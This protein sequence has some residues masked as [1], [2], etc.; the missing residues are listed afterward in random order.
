VRRFQRMSDAILAAYEEDLQRPGSLPTSRACASSKRQAFWKTPRPKTGKQPG[1]SHA[2]EEARNSG[3]TLFL[4]PGPE[5]QS[6]A[7]I[8]TPGFHLSSPGAQVGY[9]KVP[10]QCPPYAIFVRGESAEVVVAIRGMHLFKESDYVTFLRTWRAS[11]VSTPPPC[12]P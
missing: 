6:L 3:L 4:A 9:A 10:L 8:S 7:N 5:A 12:S 1:K 11:A 2:L